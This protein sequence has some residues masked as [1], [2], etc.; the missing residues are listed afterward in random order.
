MRTLPL[1]NS[2]QPLAAGPRWSGV[3]DCGAI[4][5]VAAGHAQRE[6][7]GGRVGWPVGVAGWGVAGWVGG[8]V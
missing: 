3:R 1:R 6:W 7:V 2:N 8:R 4:C 5:L